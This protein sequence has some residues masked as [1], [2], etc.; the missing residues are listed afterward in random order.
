MLERTLLKLPLKSFN[1]FTIVWDWRCLDNIKKC[2]KTCVSTLSIYIKIAH[3]GWQTARTFCQAC[4]DEDNW[5]E[6][7]S[8]GQSPFC[9]SC[10]GSLTKNFLL[11]RMWNFT[12]F[13]Y[14][15]GI[16]HRME[17]N[18]RQSLNI[19]SITLCNKIK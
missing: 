12:R 15:H 1:I 10:L 17:F 14:G 3:S 6:D 13:F 8:K 9:Q 18:S 11:A 7:R 16:R 5:D 2:L 19:F 4:Q